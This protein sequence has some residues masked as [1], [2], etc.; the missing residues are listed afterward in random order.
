M[1]GGFQWGGSIELGYRLTDINGSKDRYKETVNLEQGLR[2]FD[3]SFWG[4]RVDDNQKGLVDSVRFNVSNVGDPY[5]AATLGIRKNQTY[6]F[7]VTYRQYKYFSERQDSDNRFF[8]DNTG[9]DTTI[10]TGTAILSIYPTEDFKLNFGYTH[11]Q[12]D[13]DAGVPMPFYFQIMDQQIDEQINEYFVSAD[14]PIASWDFHVKQTIWDYTD[15]D[16][17]HGPQFQNLD[18]FVRTYVTSLKAHTHVG[19]RMDVDVGYTY[20]HSGGTADLL[21]LPETT[22]LSGSGKFDFNTQIVEAGLSYLLRKGLIFHADYRFNTQDQRGNAN[23]DTFLNAPGTSSSDYDLMTHTGIFQLE[24]IPRDNLTLRGGYEVQYEHIYGDNYYDAGMGNGNGGK[25]PSSNTNWL[26]GW[27]A[28]A[29]WK[30]Y[31]VLSLFGE[32]SGA[33]FSNPYTWISPEN[34]NVAR[35]KIKYD[36][37][38]KNLTLKGNFSWR[39]ANNPDQNYRTNVQDYTITATYL[40][41]PKASLDGSFTYERVTENTNIFNP[42]PFTFQQVIFDSDAYIWSGGVSFDDIYKGLG[43]R[44]HGSYGKTLG[45]NPENY[46]DGLISIWYKNKVITPTVTLERTYLTDNVVHRNGF[47]ANLVTFS[48]RKDF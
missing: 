43:A 9:F 18:T 3:L 33:N 4:Q 46:V 10:R 45:E 12:R 26:N 38:I 14:F 42:I 11:A 32:Y 23:T 21:T 40:P 8:A 15:T 16:K 28:S 27:I 19:E 2:L 34:Q 44:I 48:L 30:P 29:S 41:I 37:P 24:Y 6:D 1:A 47:N 25:S 17:I 22:V 35:V 31:K 5:T 39:Y 13:G 7:N 36:T 20:A